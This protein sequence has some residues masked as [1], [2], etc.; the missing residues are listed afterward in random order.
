MLGWH[1]DWLT[2]MIVAGFLISAVVLVLLSISLFILTQYVL[3]D[4]ALLIRIFL[5]I[6]YAEQRITYRQIESVFL[7][8]LWDFRGREQYF[9]IAK[10]QGKL[11]VNVMNPALGTLLYL[12][13]DDFQIF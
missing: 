6:K 3:T 7:F 9:I 5:V 10:L 2:V 11:S 1:L 8:V 13:L 12:Y 4:D